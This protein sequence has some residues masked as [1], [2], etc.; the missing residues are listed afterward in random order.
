[1]R[2]RARLLVVF[3]TPA[4]QR[5]HVLRAGH[6]KTEWHAAFSMQPCSKPKRPSSIHSGRRA[7][8][9]S[10]WQLTEHLTERSCHS[11]IRV[12]WHNRLLRSLVHQRANGRRRVLSRRRSSNRG[13]PPLC[14]SSS[15][16]ARP[17]ADRWRPRERVS[18]GGWRCAVIRRREP[19]PGAQ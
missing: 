18:A 1:M 13:E 15:R 2:G 14:L 5:C 4:L 12:A 19:R 3:S 10:I 17:K 9:P 11:C 8:A 7:Q 6:G 16:S